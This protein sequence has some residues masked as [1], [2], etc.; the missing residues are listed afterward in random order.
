MPKIQKLLLAIMLA[1]MVVLVS[2]DIAKEFSE[3]LEEGGATSIWHVFIEGIV[4]IL[5]LV[6]L[7]QLYRDVI[8][9]QSEKINLSKQLNETKT[10]LEASHLLLKEG[11]KH[12]RKVID[13][14]FRKWSLTKSEQIVALLLLK[15]LSFK[16]I[17]DQ[18][19]T[20]EKTVRH[21]ATSIYSKSE[22]SGRH[23]LAAWFFEDML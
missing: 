3:L 19:H 10:Q 18:R 2:T 13:W 1:A 4:V 22:L 17:A 23:A 20:Q 7:L 8:K 9:Q 16:E 11:K 15:G 21:H 12:F 5:S 6:I 14:Q